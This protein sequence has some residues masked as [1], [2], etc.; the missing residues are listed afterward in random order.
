LEQRYAAQLE[1]LELMGFPNREANLR[2]RAA[3]FGDVNAAVERLLASTSQP[4]QQ[5][6]DGA[7]R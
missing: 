5:Q 3:T 4:Q 2:A 6:R 1:Q 7:A